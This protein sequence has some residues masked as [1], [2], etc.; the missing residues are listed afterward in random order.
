MH[1][2]N[3]EKFLTPYPSIVL[4]MRTKGLEKYRKFYHMQCDDEWWS[5]CFFFNKRLLACSCSYRITQKR[6]MEEENRKTWTQ[7]F[8]FFFLKQNKRENWESSDSTA[9]WYEI[10]AQNHICNRTFNLCSS[11]FWA[12]SMLRLFVNEISVWILVNAVLPAPAY[13]NRFNF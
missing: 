3:N 1:E 9:Y 12:R 10:T 13:K 4:C 2:N 6:W 5:I 11:S 7:Y 8:C